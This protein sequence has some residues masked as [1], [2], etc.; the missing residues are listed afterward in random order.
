MQPADIGDS[1]IIVLPLASAELE[2]EYCF[3]NTG[4]WKNVLNLYVAHVIIWIMYTLH[5]CVTNLL[6]KSLLG[7]GEN[8]VHI[9][10]ADWSH[11]LFWTLTKYFQELWT[12]E[13]TYNFEL[14]GSV[15]GIMQSLL[16]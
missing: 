9:W 15:I 11:S 7:T 10:K 13:V 1:K 2:S 6:G 3:D 12:N 8:E 5:I 16:Y 14:D 4:S